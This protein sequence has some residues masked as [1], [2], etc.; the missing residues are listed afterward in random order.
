M[1]ALIQVVKEAEV[2]S[3]GEVLGRIDSGLSVFLGIS[4]EDDA[5]SARKLAEKL[6]ELRII[7]D[8]S[9]KMN[10][11]VQ[12]TD[13]GLLVISQFTLCGEIDSGRRPNF[14]GAA[15]YKVA[16]KLYEYFVDFIRT[17]TDLEVETGEFGSYMEVDLINDGPVTF[18]LE[19]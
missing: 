5:K 19:S 11:S 7:P 17:N 9:G 14:S 4:E 13:G 18:S 3:D 8:D 15:D 16:K 12:D 6:V 1:K 2:R 10:L